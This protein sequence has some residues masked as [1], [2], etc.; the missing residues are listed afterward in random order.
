MGVGRG[1]SSELTSWIHLRT[2]RIFF[3]AKCFFPRDI[4]I[5]GDIFFHCPLMHHSVAS[6][7]ESYPQILVVSFLGNRKYLEIRARDTIVLA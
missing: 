7:S 4:F 1:L 5:F 3:I 6:D 2:I